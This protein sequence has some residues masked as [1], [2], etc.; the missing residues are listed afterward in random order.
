MA[1]FPLSSRHGRDETGHI[2][3]KLNIKSSLKYFFQ[4]PSEGRIY[5]RER[6]YQGMAIEDNGAPENGYCIR[7]LT[8]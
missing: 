1:R 2:H 5:L 8:V 3:A 7:K 6:R 4:I